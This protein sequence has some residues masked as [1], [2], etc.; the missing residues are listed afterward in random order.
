VLLPNM[1]IL[2]WVIVIA[3][4]VILLGGVKLVF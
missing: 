3:I 4:V 1:G 2:G